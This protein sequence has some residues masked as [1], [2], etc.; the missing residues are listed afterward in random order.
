MIRSKQNGRYPNTKNVVTKRVK[1]KRKK[2][3]WRKNCKNGHCFFFYFGLFSDGA[4]DHK[5]ITK[6]GDVFL[7]NSMTSLGPITLRVFGSELPRALT[8]EKL[9]LCRAALVHLSLG[10]PFYLLPF[11]SKLFKSVD[12]IHLIPNAKNKIIHSDNSR[13]VIHL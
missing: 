10:C 13:V 7:V 11:R 5:P 12:L 4:R 3:R 9:S 8:C 6:S 2:K 1:K